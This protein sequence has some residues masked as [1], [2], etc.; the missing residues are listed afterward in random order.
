MLCSKCGKE[1]RSGYGLAGGGMGVYFMC[2]TEG[3]ETFQKFEDSEMANKPT[4][5]LDFDGV[6]HSYTSPWKGASIVSDPPVPGAI[7]FLREAV[8]EYTVAI[9]SSRSHQ[10]G[11]LEAMQEWL[12]YNAKEDAHSDEDLKW[13]EEIEWPDYK[14]S[15]F[16]TIDDRALRFT[17]EWPSLDEIRLFKPWNKK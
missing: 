10:E 6:I 2:E 9:Y 12:E 4:L 1:M 15:A 3:C 14:P 7:A 17:G 5:C 16:L 11:G 13:L 8:K